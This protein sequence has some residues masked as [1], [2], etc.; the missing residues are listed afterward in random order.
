MKRLLLL[1]FLLAAVTTFA[2]T[3]TCVHDHC[4]LSPSTNEL[5]TA[6]DN[7][8][9]SIALRALAKSYLKR[10][11]KR[12]SKKYIRSRYGRMTVNQAADYAVDEAFDYVEQSLSP[13]EQRHVTTYWNKGKSN[14]AHFGSC[15]I[16]LR[17]GDELVTATSYTAPTSSGEPNMPSGKRSKQNREPRTPSPYNGLRLNLSFSAPR[18]EAAFHQTVIEEG[19]AI[20]GGSVSLEYQVSV[21]QFETGYKYFET[22]NENL[23]IDSYNL[24]GIYGIG[25]ITL[26]WLKVIA[27]SV[28]GG[29]QLGRVDFEQNGRPTRFDNHGVLLHGALSINPSPKWSIQGRYNRLI[30]AD[31]FE[32]ELFEVGLKFRLN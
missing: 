21:L 27:P 8:F 31:V 6:D 17:A 7:P 5:P 2:C 13:Q 10:Q 24:S 16:C 26:P 22:Q 23:N 12:Q 25:S 20:G 18:T 14:T 19:S 11:V 1:F 9:L 28:G 4:T 3:T 30:Q 32:T 15:R 29:Y